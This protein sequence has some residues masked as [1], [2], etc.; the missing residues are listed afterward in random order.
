[1]PGS[2]G[3]AVFLKKNTRMIAL[4]FLTTTPGAVAARP[5]QID[6]LDAFTIGMWIRPS[7]I[8]NGQVMGL[9]EKTGKE[10]KAGKEYKIELYYEPNKGTADVRISL[11]SPDGMDWNFVWNSYVTV[12]A[13][14]QQWSHLAVVWNSRAAQPYV[15]IAVNGILHK[16]NYTGGILTVGSGDLVF[17]ASKNQAASSFQYYNGSMDE[18]QV[19]HVARRDDDLVGIRPHRRLLVGSEHG[20]GGYWHFDEG[21]G[22][23]AMVLVNTTISYLYFLRTGYNPLLT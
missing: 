14:D 22:T 12:P 19:W 17:G 4:P 13:D 21:F 18:I 23:Y 11:G 6:G 10:G 9:V 7:E 5:K 2:A 8:G 1:M 16:K 15:G 20:L 3:Y